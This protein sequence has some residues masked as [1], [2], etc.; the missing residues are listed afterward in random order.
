MTK[1]MGILAAIVACALTVTLLPA[2]AQQQS[3]PTA[4]PRRRTPDS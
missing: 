4:I 2:A 1:R 3:L